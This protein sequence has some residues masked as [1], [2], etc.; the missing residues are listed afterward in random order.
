LRAS[1]IIG[2]YGGEEFI[3]LIVLQGEIDAEQAFERVRAAVAAIDLSADGRRVP[4]TV[5]IG[6]TTE[7]GNS[8]NQMIE[9]ADSAV[10]R[11]KAE[12]RNRVMR[13]ALPRAAE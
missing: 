9:Q 8:L 5:S 2:R 6:F 10:Y 1:D 13:W 3:C 11:A 4:L 12:G 7:L